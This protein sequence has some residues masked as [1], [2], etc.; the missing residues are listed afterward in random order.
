MFL[1][2]ITTSSAWVISQ[3]TGF[4]GRISKQRAIDRE[5]AP[6][7]GS[8][9][10]NGRLFALPTLPSSARAFILNADHERNASASTVLPVS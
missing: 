8:C 9:A 4:A 1:L 6:F 7:E 2:M 10:A 5:N 3:F